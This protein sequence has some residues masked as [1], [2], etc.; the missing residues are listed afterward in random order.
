MNNTRHLI[1]NSYKCPS[2]VSTNNINSIVLLPINYYSTI[3]IVIDSADFFG[4][5]FT[6]VD[7]NMK[8]MYSVIKPFT[9]ILTFC[10]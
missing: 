6:K 7:S 3:S 8:N 5:N 1:Y 10:Y 2:F 4:N 9:T